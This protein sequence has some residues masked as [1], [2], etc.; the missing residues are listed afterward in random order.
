MHAEN[1]STAAASIGE[2]APSGNTVQISPAGQS[3][4]VRQVACAGDLQLVAQKVVAVGPPSAE[5]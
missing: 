4:L 3:A 2:L 1:D 5:A